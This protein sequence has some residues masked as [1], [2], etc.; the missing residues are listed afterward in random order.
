MA[1]N[2]DDGETLLFKSYGDAQKIK[3]TSETK[4]GS[5]KDDI[6]KSDSS[7]ESDSRSSSSSSKKSSSSSSSSSTSGSSGKIA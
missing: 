7:K 4:K 5:L 1:L 2:I 3:E 6:D